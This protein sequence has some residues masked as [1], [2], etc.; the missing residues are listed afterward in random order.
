VLADGQDDLATRFATKGIERFSGVEIERGATGVP[1]LA[2]VSARFECRTA[3]QYEGGDHV[4]FV[5]EVISYEHWDRDPLVFKHGRF[6]R[7]VHK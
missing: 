3:F 2:G 7:A 4:I 5:G 6:A 1:L